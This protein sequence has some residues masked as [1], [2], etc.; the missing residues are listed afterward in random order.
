MLPAARQPTMVHFTHTWIYRSAEPCPTQTPT[1]YGL[2][3]R[4][5]ERPRESEH[6]GALCSVCI[7]LLPALEM[8]TQHRGAAMQSCIPPPVSY[9]ETTLAWISQDTAWYLQHSTS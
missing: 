9:N 1:S 5:S 4:D 7:L 3:A 8:H 6:N 2:A